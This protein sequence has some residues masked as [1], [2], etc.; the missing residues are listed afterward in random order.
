MDTKDGTCV[1]DFTHVADLADGF[2]KALLRQSDG[3]LRGWHT[4]NLGTGISTTV[5]EFINAFRDLSG[6]TINHTVVQKRAQDVSY[7]VSDSTK[8]RKDLGWS[9][10]RSLTDICNDTIL[11]MSQI[12]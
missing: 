3:D 8:S 10:K 1:R 6:K 2:I 4:Y 9:A 12:I 5:L 7:V 11:F